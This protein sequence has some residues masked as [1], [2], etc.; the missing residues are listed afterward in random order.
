MDI[1]QSRLAAA[2]QSGGVSSSVIYQAILDAA[3]DACPSPTAVL[4]FGSGTGQLLPQLA[5]TFRG[6]TLHAVDIMDRPA[7]L[8][9]SVTWHKSD[10]NDETTIAAQS[11]DMI[12]AAEVI[13]HLENPRQMIREIARLLTRGGVAILSTPNTGSIRSLI[14]FAARGHHAQFDDTNYPAHITPVSDVDFARMAQEAGLRLERFFFTN[15]GTIPK[16][17]SHRWQRVPVIGSRFQGKRFSDN[18]GVVLRKPAI[19]S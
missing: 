19:D 18:F 5:A 10:L 14:T 15:S 17:L 16:L 6:A 1:E 7:D 9:V 11:F 3:R 8:P 12:V 13:E 4:D 2:M